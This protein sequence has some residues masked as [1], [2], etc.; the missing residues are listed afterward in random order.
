MA[1]P[2]IRKYYGT[3][4]VCGTPIGAE[5]RC[6]DGNLQV[7]ICKEGQISMLEAKTCESSAVP[8]VT[9]ALQFGFHFIGCLV[10]YLH[11]KKRWWLY[12]DTRRLPIYSFIDVFFSRDT[13]TT[14]EAARFSR[15]L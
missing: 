9:C 15:N 12:F 11:S 4:I 6:C 8:I 1:K 7:I 14:N 3:V 13:G 2:I 10:F 5:K